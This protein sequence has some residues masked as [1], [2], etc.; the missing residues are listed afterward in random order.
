MTPQEKN[1]K[2]RVSESLKVHTNLD[3]HVWFILEDKVRLTLIAYQEQFK[4]ASDWKTPLS[5]FITIVLVII[6]ANFKDF[7]FISS[8]TISGIAYAAAIFFGAATIVNGW[9]AIRRKR[10]TIDDVIQELRES[11]DQQKESKNSDDSSDFIT[12]KR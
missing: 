3:Q 10:V 1:I 11:S 4:E 5:L 7:P 12:V 6:S 9:K 8:A 2:A